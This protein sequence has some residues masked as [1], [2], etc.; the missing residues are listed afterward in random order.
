[1]RLDEMNVVITGANGVLASYL[2]EYFSNRVAFVVGTARQL[3]EVSR[4]KNNEA[5]IEMDPLDHHSIDNAIEWTN[6]EAG[7]IHVWLN[8]IGGFT[9]GNYVE[10]GRDD[11]IYMYNTNFITALNC[12]QRI[13]PLMKRRGWGRIIN[14]GSQTALR[15]MPLAGPYCASKSAVHSLTQTIALENCNGITCNA[16]VPGI[17]DTP[18][19]RNNM[20]DADHRGWV[21]LEGLAQNIEKLLLSN[22]NGPL[23]EI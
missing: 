10:E 23:L 8:I 9:M 2:L 5:I 18:A 12:C 20:P 19:N 6:N 4:P 15:G 11:W 17:I 14:M 16:I 7:D 3:A 13:L 22:E 21:A 1:M